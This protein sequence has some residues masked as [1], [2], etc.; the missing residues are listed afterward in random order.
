MVKGGE[1]LNISWGLS[2]RATRYHLERSV[3][4]AAYSEIYSGTAR[5]YDDPI[6]KGWL[7]V[8]YRVRG[9]NAD[10]YSAY[11]TGTNLTTVINFPDIFQNINGTYVAFEASWENVNGVWVE[12]DSI[13]QNINGTWV[14]V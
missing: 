3:D 6:T 1:S 9:Y 4:G 2:T 10:G 12:T 8:Q 11:R 7:T 5:V 13:W 14:E